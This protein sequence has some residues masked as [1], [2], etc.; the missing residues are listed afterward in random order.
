MK[1]SKSTTEEKKWRIKKCNFGKRK[2]WYSMVISY[3][4][5]YLFCAWHERIVQCTKSDCCMYLIWNYGDGTNIFTPV[6]WTNTHIRKWRRRRRSTR[7]FKFWCFF[8]HSH[9]FRRLYLNFGWQV[10]LWAMLI[11]FNRK[12]MSL[13]ICLLVCFSGQRD[14]ANIDFN[15]LCHH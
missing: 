8:Y 13:F 1:T 11:T 4:M 3:G 6:M 9:Q 12:S 10:N 7:A 2:K 5:E 15:H 14:P